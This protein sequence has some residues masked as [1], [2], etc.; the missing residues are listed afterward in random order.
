MLSYFDDI[1]DITD[2]F[3][4][5]FAPRKSI[6]SAFD[7]RVKL[8]GDSLKISLD[9]PG[10][11]KEDVDVTFEAGDVIKVVAKRFD[12]G[13]TTTWRYAVAETW[14]RESADAKLEDG[15]LTIVLTKREQKDKSR[16]LLVK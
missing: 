13:A 8:D 11:K 1:L 6:H 4:P 14:D 7:G 10:V 2:R 5:L 16:K 12:T 15:V 9:V 3:E